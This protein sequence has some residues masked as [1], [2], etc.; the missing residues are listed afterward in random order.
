M[1]NPINVVHPCHKNYVDN[2]V[3]FLRRCF[4]WVE[5]SPTFFVF[6]AFWG[7]FRFPFFHRAT[8]CGLF[9]L[10]SQAKTT[11]KVV[12]RMECVTCKYRLQKALKRCKHFELGGDKKRKVRWVSA[13]GTCFVFCQLPNAHIVLPARL[14]GQMIQY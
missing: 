1:T 8:H 12:L 6:S 14:Q 4:V 2:V 5:V 11:K 9:L 7:R 13:G 3:V 10:A